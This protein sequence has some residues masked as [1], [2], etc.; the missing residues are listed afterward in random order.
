[1]GDYDRQGPFFFIN[2]NDGPHRNL[3]HAFIR[4]DDSLHSRVGQD[5]YCD[6]KNQNCP[7]L[8]WI[9]H[10]G[11]KYFPDPNNQK[12]WGLQ[13]TASSE[14]TGLTGGYGWF[15]HWVDR[16]PKTVSFERLEIFPDSSLMISM[17]YPQG[18][19]FKITVSAGGC[20]ANAKYSCLQE[21]QQ[22]NDIEEVRRL[23]NKYHLSSSG[24]LT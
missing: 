1:M 9:R 14:I 5:S 18:T 4:W 8:G 13:L 6:V 7:I 22:T 3:A 12:T 23:G 20:R 15:L 16:A 10:V 11:R 24:V 19:T 17:P 2:K 21:F